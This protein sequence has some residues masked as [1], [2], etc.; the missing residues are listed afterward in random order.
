MSFLLEE[1]E[2]LDGQPIALISFKSKCVCG[3]TLKIKF[4]IKT[5]KHLNMYP[6]INIFIK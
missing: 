1:M 4:I 3:V 5:E 2:P 6:K